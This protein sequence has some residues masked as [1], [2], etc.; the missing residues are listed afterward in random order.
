MRVREPAML[1][2]ERV[3]K[4]FA[5]SA[6]SAALDGVSLELAPGEFAT[7]VGSNGAGKTTL[8]QVI[9]GSVAP[10]EGRVLV[11][12][13]EVTP[14][15]QHRRAGWVGMVFQDPGAGTAGSLTVEENM[16]LAVTAGRR[17]TLL[18]AVRPGRREWVVHSLRMLGMGLE[19]RL[20]APVRTLSGGQ[21]QA[22]ALLMAA[23]R[24]PR[25]LLLDEHTASLDPQAAEAML[26]LTQQ[27]VRDLRLTALMVTHNL[28][29]ALTV[30]DRTI[31]MHRGRVV[32][33]LR[34]AERRRMDVADLAEAFRRACHEVL[35]DDHLIL[36]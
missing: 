10:D 32:L 21:R 27:L 19:H 12:G 17:R 11:A 6:Q 35:A 31:I 14:W 16:V 20:D 8:L 25:L 2:V 18:P 7:V 30:G 4:R 3:V 28:K 1:R 33:D 23:A 5:Q 9:A 13:Q 22:L 34:G 26:H 29:H 24:R 36:A 15:P